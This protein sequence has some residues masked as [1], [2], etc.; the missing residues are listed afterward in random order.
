MLLDL[1]DDL[2]LLI[3]LQFS[4]AH[5][6]GKTAPTCRKFKEIV[7]KAFKIR[8]YSGEILTLDVAGHARS[9]LLCVAAL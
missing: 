7:E 2:L 3:I 5:E 4:L 9:D 8:L 6:I 1:P